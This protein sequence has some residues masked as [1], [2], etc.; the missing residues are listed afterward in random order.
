MAQSNHSVEIEV[1]A[2]TA[3]AKKDLQEIEKMLNRL[4]QG[5]KVGLGAG[6]GGRGGSGGGGSAPA[7]MSKQAFSQQVSLSMVKNIDKRLL[8]QEKRTTKQVLEEE[9]RRTRAQEV[10]NEHRRNFNDA[11]YKQELANIESNKLSHKE[12]EVRKTQNEKDEIKKRQEARKEAAAEKKR[13]NKETFQDE[14]REKRQ[15]DRIAAMDHQAKLRREDRAEKEKERK[16]RR[17][18]LRNKALLV[19]GAYLGYRGVR[20]AGETAVGIGGASSVGGAF[21]SLLQGVSALPIVGG[22]LAGAGQASLAGVNARTALQQNAAQFQPRLAQVTALTGATRQQQLDYM[23]T[24]ASNLGIGPQRSMQQLAAVSAGSGRALSGTELSRLSNLGLME[25]LVGG[26]A[27]SALSFI[28]SATLG[29]G[30]GGTKSAFGELGRIETFRRAQGLLP[31]ESSM[32]RQAGAAFRQ[33]GLAQGFAM[34]ESSLFGLT[35]GIMSTGRS[36]AAQSLTGAMGLAQRERQLGFGAFQ[37]FAGQ[38][39]DLPNTLL[40]AQA[41]QGGGGIGGIFRRLSKLSATPGASAKAL[42]TAVSQFN[43]PRE[44]IQA[45]VSS[46][47]GVGYG[48]AGDVLGARARKLTSADLSNKS[49]SPEMARF[50]GEDIGLTRAFAGGEMGKLLSGFEFAGEESVA[51]LNQLLQANI[52]SE[53]RLAKLTEN[54]LPDLIRHMET[55]NK[56][57]AG[58]VDKLSEALVEGANK[59]ETLS[60]V[61][62]QKLSDLGSLFGG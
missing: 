45:G 5:A 29:R 22:L 36:G 13:L 59:I 2:Q 49:M 14:Q 12:A 20:R 32:L 16:E 28:R 60:V 37:D 44:L 57:F 39:A 55:L 6:G 23:G 27:Q 41:A 15:A 40:L 33:Q 9:K 38:F 47:L 30:R 51:S 26:D 31:A 52:R 10:E 11:M 43:I 1:T 17:R 48:A 4:S 7:A 8:E 24:V 54:Q 61:V 46:R 62:R 35:Q 25:E 56:K 34:D 58:G 3:Q 42:S 50:L 53:E 21:S 18:R 19:G